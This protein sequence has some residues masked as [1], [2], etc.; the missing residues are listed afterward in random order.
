M[1]GLN[2]KDTRTEVK[3]MA[4]RFVAA[5]EVVCYVL[6][7]NAYGAAM[8]PWLKS[9]G[10]AVEGF[11]NDSRAGDRFE[12]LP[13]IAMAQVPADAALVNCIVEGRAVEA[14]NNLLSRQ[15]AV[16]ADYFMLQASAPG[17]LP[18]IQF[19]AATA[20]IE[21]DR[22]A[23]ERLYERLADDLSKQTLEQ[24]LNFR[25]NRDI[26]FLEDFKFRLHEQYF[27]PF[28]ELSEQPAFVDGGGFDGATSKIFASLHPDHRDI[29]YFEPNTG[30]FEQSKQQ[31]KG[32]PHVRLF[33]KGLWHEDAVL[34]FDGSM[35]SAS[36]L[37][38]TGGVSIETT[39]IDAVV[40]GPVHFIKLD[41][42]GAE[43]NALQG[44]EATIRRERPVLAVC[45][46][47]DQ[48]DFWRIPEQV[49]QYHPDYKVYLRHY[50]QGVFETVMYFV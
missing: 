1:N 23:Y 47:H 18:E 39:S 2:W 30:S 22:E 4:E 10:R 14:R 3:A 48:Q 40:N 25:W 6:G 44:A 34:H 31:L 20:T 17:E 19:M 27:E 15:P 28:V 8:V 13:V 21:K 7:T 45:V 38:D 11:I 29:Y 9:R 12:D 41:I 33:K 26:R 46:Y 5:P 35:G 50:T 43:L 49:L 16:Y 42:E 36:K 32:V 24:L 37:S